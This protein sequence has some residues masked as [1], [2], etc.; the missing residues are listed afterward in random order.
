MCLLLCFLFWWGW[1]RYWFPALAGRLTRS[2]LVS[3]K[4]FQTFF[5]KIEAKRKFFQL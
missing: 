3:E 2:S 5:Q 1:F 4:I